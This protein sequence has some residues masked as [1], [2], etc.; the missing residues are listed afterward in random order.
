MENEGTPNDDGNHGVRAPAVTFYDNIMPMFGDSNIACMKSQNLDLGNYEQV[1][2]YRTKIYDVLESGFMPLGGPRWTPD[3][4]KTFRDW[5]SQ[6]C[7]GTIT[8]KPRIRPNIINIDADYLSRVKTAFEKL[9][10]IDGPGGY[11]WLVDIHANY[12]YHHSQKFF[13]WHRLFMIVFEDA[14][15]NA[16]DDPDLCLPYWDFTT[17]TIPEVL[18]RE[19]FH[20]YSSPTAFQTGMYSNGT[21]DNPVPQY[22]SLRNPLHFMEWKY[23]SKGV[24]ES[25]AEGLSQNVWEQFTGW[26]PNNTLTGATVHA[27][28]M[29]HNFMGVTMQ[30]S[31]FSPF[32]PIFWFY[33]CNWDRIFAA[34]QQEHNAVS[35][36]DFVLHLQDPNDTAWLHDNGLAPFKV[37]DSGTSSSVS[38]MVGDLEYAS[39]SQTLDIAGF[40]IEYDSYPTPKSIL[41]NISPSPVTFH[42]KNSTAGSSGVDAPGSHTATIRVEGVHRLAI[43]GNFRVAIVACHT[44]DEI[45]QLTYLQR[46]QPAQCTNCANTPV[47]NFEFKIHHDQ[48]ITEE[49]VDFEITAHGHIVD[50][51]TVGNPSMTILQG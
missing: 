10:S 22:T 8:G 43:S 24:A 5:V 12:C 34:W 21:I 18:R 15:R 41:D 49:T 37:A 11:R 23:H 27:H 42:D 46:K 3:Q 40:N 51:A 44:R 30:D 20:I 38:V 16:A 36:N 26:Y 45:A 17:D 29:G 31:Q 4:L 28:N 35:Y 14:L 47:V 33:H 2:M 48:P 25:T 50:T 19:P 1:K 9:Y 7:H 13:T 6:G 39:S 32:D